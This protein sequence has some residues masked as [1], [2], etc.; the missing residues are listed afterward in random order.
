MTIDTKL[1]HLI[2][3]GALLASARPLTVAQ[4]AE[5]FEDEERPANDMIR[6]A[7]EDIQ[8]DCSGRGYELVEVRK[9]AKV[10]SSLAGDAV[11]NRLSTTH[12]S[13]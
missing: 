13:R 12:H 2:L 7:L 9:T 1:L 10:F 4:L 3:E 5:L 6:A 8:Q 11:F